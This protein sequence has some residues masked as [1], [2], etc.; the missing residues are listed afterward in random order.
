MVGAKL[1]NSQN[2]PWGI[3]PGY[4]SHAYS[5]PNWRSERSTL[6]ASASERDRAHNL[7][8]NEE[9]S[10]SG[11]RARPEQPLGP[12][13]ALST[14]RWRH[15]GTSARCS[16]K[17]SS[18]STSLSPVIEIAVLLGDGA[19]V[20]GSSA[21]AGA[22]ASRPMATRSVSLATV[23][24]KDLAES[25][26]MAE[27]FVAY[28]VMAHIFMPCIVMVYVVMAHVVMVGM[29]VFGASSAARRQSAQGVV[30]EH[31]LHESL[32]ASTV[33]GSSSQSPVPATKHSMVFS[34]MR[35]LCR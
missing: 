28:T 17:M 22:G 20:D 32:A 25:T 18:R 31:W 1:A 16:R 35:C 3:L 13:L 24:N 29:E 21:G 15:S 2:T 6:S 7:A 23:R 11:A 27:V 8:G 9:P 10:S 34:R 19:T 33:A 30:S 26:R 12:R 14:N 4:S 5:Q